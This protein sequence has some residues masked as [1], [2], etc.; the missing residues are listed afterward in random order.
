MVV[1]VSKHRAWVKCLFPP[2]ITLNPL[3]LIFLIFRH[4]DTHYILIFRSATPRPEWNSERKIT[5]YKVRRETNYSFWEGGNNSPKSLAETKS[6]A[7][8]GAW[9]WC[10]EASIQPPIS[11]SSC[12]CSSSC[13]GPAPPAYWSCR[14]RG[15]PAL[16]DDAPG[17][18]PRQDDPQCGGA[19]QQVPDVLRDTPGVPALQDLQPG[20]ARPQ[21]DPRGARGRPQLQSVPRAPVL[22]WQGLHSPGPAH[23]H[24]ARP[25]HHPS[26]PPPPAL[27]LTPTSVRWRRPGWGSQQT[28]GRHWWWDCRSQAE[29][30]G[31]IGLQDIWSQGLYKDKARETI[32]QE[33]VRKRLRKRK[34]SILLWTI[35]LTYFFSFL[36]S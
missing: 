36:R 12:S 8:D 28:C 30:P 33:R 21:D 26:P 3:N 15:E 24:P 22:R 27:Q 9:R 29:I 11:S 17:V 14:V 31:E 32:R 25:P 23:H 19:G 6:G 18:A 16:P 13:R 20:D 1:G 34:V 5:F 2:I 10:E 35:L 7:E 4:N